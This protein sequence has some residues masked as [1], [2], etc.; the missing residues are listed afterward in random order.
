MDTRHEYVSAPELVSML[1]V[2]C[3]VVTVIRLGEEAKVGIIFGFHVEHSN[4]A[5]NFAAL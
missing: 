3:G 4:M 5:T 2:E 1:C